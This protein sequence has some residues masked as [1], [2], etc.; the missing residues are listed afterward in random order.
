MQPFAELTN[1][2]FNMTSAQIS[3][4]AKDGA[5]ANTTSQL[6]RSLG[7][8][9][10]I[11]AKGYL[12]TAADFSFL[13]FIDAFYFS[14][15]DTNIT[16][17]LQLLDGIRS[18]CGGL[19]LPQQTTANYEYLVQAQ[20]RQLWGSYTANSTV[21]GYNAS[22]QTTDDVLTELYSGAQAEGWCSS[23][24]N[25]YA[26]ASKLGGYPSS[27]NASLGNVA[28]QRIE[29]IKG[30]VGM[31]SV[32]AQQAYA[33][34]EFAV[35]IIDSD[36]AYA[37]QYSVLASA[38]MSIGAML[39]R[40]DAIARNSTYGAW[41][42]QFANE[43]E[44]YIQQA[45][46]THNSS[47]LADYAE[48]ALSSAVLASQI[49]NDTSII[50]QSMGATASQP[51]SN[52]GGTATSSEIISLNDIS[53]KLYII[54]LMV[55]TVAMGIFGLLVGMLMTYIKN[56]HKHQEQHRLLEEGRAARRQRRTNAK[57]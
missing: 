55:L 8:S 1:E 39:N 5:F 10:A 12:Y 6:R 33:R 11:G 19:T 53:N 16:E 29:R 43:A 7:Q 35:A 18:Y 42:T 4:F 34:K 50:A 23:A 46:A 22:V 17:G 21:A 13:S 37:Q 20:M 44:F 52:G 47:N 25:I 45:R 9:M 38:N 48:S 41:A 57:E 36:Y 40:S 14:N 51:S 32:T 3:N 54:S 15:N 24:D 31:Y 30:S 2:T 27:F 49:S 26:D 56:H 28:Y